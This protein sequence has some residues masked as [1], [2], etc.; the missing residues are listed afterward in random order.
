VADSE[1]EAELEEALVKAAATLA[2]V[3]GRVIAQ[4]SERR[5]AAAPSG[6]CVAAEPGRRSASGIDPRPGPARRALSVGPRPD[7]AEGVFETL[8]T[9]DGRPQFLTAHLQRLAASVQGLYGHSLEPELPGRVSVAGAGL[10]RGRIRVHIRPDGTVTLDASPEP[11]S[12]RDAPALRLAPWW[13]P[14]GLGAHKWI[15]RRLLVALGAAEPATVPLLLDGDGAVLEAG[16][17]NVWI[18]EAGDW[19]TPPADGRILPGV[20]RALL[21]ANPTVSTR[22]ESFDLARLAGADAVFLTSAVSGRRRAVL[23]GR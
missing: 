4:P 3:G 13:L 10:A 1:P 2:A 22:E 17:A 12:R 9:Q 5:V 7:P 8:L 6:P 18:V 20:T 19:I 16:W 14:G 21:L 15:D 11:L 23:A